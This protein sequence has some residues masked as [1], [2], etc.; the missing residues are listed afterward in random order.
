[1]E[2][3][4]GESLPA[5]VP[6][7]CGDDHNADSDSCSLPRPV[8]NNESDDNNASTRP[9]PPGVGDSDDDNAC[10][11]PPPVSAK[12]DDVTT[13]SC[14]QETCPQQCAWLVTR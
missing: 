6:F 8:V 12:A 11:L 9:V 5:P 4:S 7:D 3:D 1:M 13:S 14:K 10:S 2:S